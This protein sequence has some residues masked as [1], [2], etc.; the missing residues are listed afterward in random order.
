MA[1]LPTL[2]PPFWHSQ[3]WAYCRLQV[4]PELLQYAAGHWASL[5]G[6][7]ACP[8]LE[9]EPAHMQEALSSCHCDELGTAK[10]QLQR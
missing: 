9:P 3:S 1:V 2:A 4:A 10:L 6:V 5:Q 7:M 8:Q